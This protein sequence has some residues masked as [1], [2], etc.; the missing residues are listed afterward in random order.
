MDAEFEEDVEHWP[1][2]TLVLGKS[3]WRGG[4]D[5]ALKYAWPDKNGKRARG[6]EIPIAAL[7]QAVIFAAKR[8]Y[9]SREQM[10]EIAKGL[11]DVLAALG[12]PGLC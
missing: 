5:K 11:V 8:D 10:Q 2:D 9:L 7:P 6:G 12:G 1:R 3:S 4:A